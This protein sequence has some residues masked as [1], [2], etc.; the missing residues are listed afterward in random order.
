LRFNQD[1]SSLWVEQEVHKDNEQQYMDMI[2]HRT[3]VIWQEPVKVLINTF[4]FPRPI[5]RRYHEL[6]TEAR[7][8]KVIAA[9]QHQ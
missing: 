5:K 2:V 6:W 7:M 3:C 8:D 4:L 9:L 1:N